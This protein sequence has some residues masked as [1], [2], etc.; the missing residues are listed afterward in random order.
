MVRKPKE[1]DLS[2]EFCGLDFENP[3]M[4]SSAPPTSSG[5]M[6]RQAFETGWGGVVVK[7]LGLEPTPNV[8]PRF[9]TLRSKDK[10]MI[11]FGNIGARS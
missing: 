10:K 7:T 6:I 1:V 9:A 5:E 4:L 8:R 2:I 3:F 11:G